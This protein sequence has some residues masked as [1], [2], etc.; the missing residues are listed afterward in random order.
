LQQIV[1]F[2]I[3]LSKMLFI[4]KVIK[5]LQD[6]VKTEYQPAFVFWQIFVPL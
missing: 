3:G 4:I 5:W 2:I 6:H 1:Q